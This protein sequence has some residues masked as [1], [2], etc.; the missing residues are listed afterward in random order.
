[1]TQKI[2]FVAAVAAGC[3]PAAFAPRQV[4]RVY[5]QSLAATPDRI[6]PL[7]TPLGERAWAEGWDPKILYTAPEPGTGTVFLTGHPGHADT[8]W[9]LEEYDPARHRVRYVRIT[10][11]SDVTQLE[12]VLEATTED[13]T[14]AT[15]RYTYTGFTDA[16]NALVAEMTEEHYARRL[17]EW[18]TAL[19]HFLLTGELHRAVH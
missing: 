4:T 16:G 15:V 5:T 12:I 2:A 10:P 14:A 13:R 3:S 1:M 17:R 18:E 8:L 11:G 7:L 6:L 19:N 9:L